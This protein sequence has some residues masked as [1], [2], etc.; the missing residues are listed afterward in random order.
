[1]RKTENLEAILSLAGTVLGLTATAITFLIK[2]IKNAKAKK[3]A[4]QTI[5]ISEAIIPYIE[6]AEQ[7]INYTGQEK[8]EFVMTKANQ[9]AIA[10]GIDFDAIAVSEKIEELVDLSSRVNK[11]QKDI[12]IY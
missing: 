5:K 9:F 11:R 6:Q 10:Q 1:M 7:F 4:E 3:I 2:F 12:T 8:K